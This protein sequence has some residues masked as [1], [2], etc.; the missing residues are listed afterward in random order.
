MGL[1]R[2][3]SAQGAP[4]KK[5][6]PPSKAS[7]TRVRR[8]AALLSRKKP[9]READLEGGGKV[10]SESLAKE[11]VGLGVLGAAVITLLSLLSYSSPALNSGAATSNW[12]GPLGARLAGTLLGWFGMTAFAFPAMLLLLSLALLMQRARRVHLLETTG[13]VAVA[14]SLSVLVELAFGAI[15]YQRVPGLTGGGRVGQGLL[16]FLEAQISQTGAGVLAVTVL[17]AGARL[18]FGVQV[19]LLARHAIALS[20]ATLRVFVR[21]VAGLGRSGG[22]SVL[23]FYGGLRE[24]LH[25]RWLDW[26]E[27]RR[28]RRD[29]ERWEREERLALLEE[30]RLDEELG[31]DPEDPFSAS[32]SLREDDDRSVG[33]EES[34][35]EDSGLESIGL[36]TENRKSRVRRPYSSDSDVQALL[37]PGSRDSQSELEAEIEDEPAPVTEAK[38]EACEVH[39]RDGIDLT[40]EVD[41]EVLSVGLVASERISTLAEELE[42]Q[43]TMRGANQR[44]EVH[45]ELRVKSSRKIS[46][47]KEPTGSDDPRS[48]ETPGEQQH[49][50]SRPR[51]H[52]KL[53][54][55]QEIIEVERVVS[56]RRVITPVDL[57]PYELPE[58]GL[59]QKPPVGQVAVDEQRLEEKATL[60]EQTLRTFKVEGR[61][62][63]IL[64]GPVVTMFEFKPAPGIKVKTIAGLGDDLAMALEADMIRIVA[65][66]PGKG[67]VGI[68]VPSDVRETVYLR[69][70]MASKAFQKEGMQLPIALGKSIDGAPVCADLAKMPHL[71]VAGSTGSG[72]SVCVNSV[73]L[74]ILYR[75]SPEE[76]R[77]ILVDPKMLEFSVYK[78]IPHLLVP[79]VTSA[80]KAAMALNW[81]VSE[82]YRRNEVLAAMN[83]RNI[84][85]Y[86]EKTEGLIT[87]WTEWEASCKSGK[88][89]VPP[90]C[91]RAAGLDSVCFRSRGGEPV[92]APEKMPYIVIIIDELSDLMMAARKEV[93]DSIVRLAQMARAAGIHLLLATQRPSTD[94]V[95]GLIKANFPGRMSFRVSSMVDSRTVLDANGA[96][97]LLGRG[98]GLFM[99]PGSSDL[100]RFHGA[101]VTD[102]ETEDV[103]E[104]IKGQRGPQYVE[105]TLPDDS[106]DG[107]ADLED[108]DSMYDQAVAVVSQAGK[109]STS[110]L[111]RKLKLGYNRAARI[112]DSMERQGVIGPADG[113][114]PREVFVQDYGA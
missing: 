4:G 34:E 15:S 82:M 103:V 77:M 76:V 22:G 100:M 65:P 2:S 17:L 11:L 37:D 83:A 41:E 39:P 99:P 109:A 31:L 26:S 13:F 1:F 112:I 75:W 51:I 95:T 21:G 29:E 38:L 45:A 27:D 59:L 10:R 113:A 70:V 93:E 96:E 61:V 43:D 14:L 19:I 79:V 55:A 54:V 72:K 104:H 24:G 49:S 16:S 81:A 5:K 6:A 108:L 56:A 3:T 67:V 32:H 58:L 106:A 30:Q 114:R 68:E 101:F 90:D 48:G 74:S 33:R 88:P 98:D 94:V 111:Q 28:L 97:R 64:P 35:S 53:D 91:G 57:P 20:R 87:E 78:D 50:E 18:G 44:G 86:N 12:I 73:I 110:L 46:G 62:T 36:G 23:A 7:K 66:I 8:G 42:P 102:G 25:D 71:L 92:G 105:L 60:L 80:K 85:N 69:E 47:S 63:D 52:E 40:E 89:K 107:G 84:V 9:R